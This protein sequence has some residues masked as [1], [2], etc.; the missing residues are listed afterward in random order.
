MPSRNLAARISGQF[1]NIASIFN[2]CSNPQ[3]EAR[4]TNVLFNNHLTD[5][6]EYPQSVERMSPRELSKLTKE[7]IQDNNTQGLFFS[8]S[9]NRI[10]KFF[11]KED[12]HMPTKLGLEDAKSIIKMAAAKEAISQDIPALA[13]CDGAYYFPVILS[14][15]LYKNNESQLL[16]HSIKI[17]ESWLLNQ[18]K[19]QYPTK[20]VSYL[21]TESIYS[22]HKL[23][24][25]IDDSQEAEALATDPYGNPAIMSFNNRRIT[26]ALDHIDYISQEPITTEDHR[27]NTSIVFELICDKFLYDISQKP[28]PDCAP[29]MNERILDILDKT[30]LTQEHFAVSY[31]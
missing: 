2:Y 1:P 27:I 7:L 3:F 29:K 21:T 24:Q 6:P 18:I 4:F 20:D 17:E 12:Q 30:D 5:Y 28:N 16:T 13:I 26:T 14:H 10:P 22:I 25:T 8:G 11:W 31:R 15:S 9:I 19:E 23:N